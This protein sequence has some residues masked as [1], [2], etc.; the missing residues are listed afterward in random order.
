MLKGG[1]VR[2]QPPFQHELDVLAQPHGIC[3]GL[4][5]DAPE[6]AEPLLVALLKYNS[7]MLHLSH[8]NQL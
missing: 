6:L 8:S 1:L 7:I 5:E 3:L 4:G 2:N